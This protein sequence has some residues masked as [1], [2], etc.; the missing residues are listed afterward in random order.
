MG[1]RAL[2]RGFTQLIGGLVAGQYRPGEKL[3]RQRTLASEMGVTM[4]TL[5]E[6]LQRL[7]QMGLIEVR[8]GDAMRVVDWHERGGLDLIPYLLLRP[9]GID[10]KLLG[11]VMEARRM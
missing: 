11:D 7:E 2:D 9:S 1:Q 10:R 6:A 5:R 3:P 4:T 8:H